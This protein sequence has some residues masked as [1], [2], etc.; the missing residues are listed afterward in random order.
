MFVLLVLLINGLFVAS[1]MWLQP[2]RPQLFAMSCLV[3]VLALVLVLRQAERRNGRIRSLLEGGLSSLHDGDYGISLPDTG[4]KQDQALIGL[5]NT[6]TDKLRREKQSLYQRELLL[7]KVVNA[8]DVVTVLLNQR[9]HVVFTNLSGQHFFRQRRIVGQDWHRLVQQ[10][11]PDLAEYEAQGNAIIQLSEDESGA[12]VQSWHL[13]RYTLQLHSV[14]HQLILLKPMT[15]EL[16]SQELKVWKQAIRVINHELNN[17]IAPISSMCHSGQILADNLN[18]P[19]LDRV[20]KTISNRVEKLSDFVRNYSRLARLSE[21]QKQQVDLRQTLEKLGSM[22]AFNLHLSDGPLLFDA[23]EGQLEQ[24]LI[25]LLKNA[26]EVC[27]QAHCDVFVSRSQHYVQINVRDTGPGMPTDVLQKAF[28]PGY[29][30]K[31]QGS[32]IGLSVCKDVVDAHGGFISLNN[33]HG[34]GLEVKV[35]LPA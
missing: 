6:M 3:L 2:A 25:N 28:L 11:R 1:V 8:S 30:T 9:D 32:G 33:H 10:Q 20:F 7:D 13:S 12:N 18:Q 35:L 5:F 29:S 14:P 4:N 16:Q 21:P 17:S 34:G 22:Y 23:D 15:R 26:N 27:P 24:L 19:Q 31:E